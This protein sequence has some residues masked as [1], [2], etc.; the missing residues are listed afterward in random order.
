MWFRIA[1]SGLDFQPRE[2]TAARESRDLEHVS[3]LN[4][5]SS[6]VG[7]TIAWS[8]GCGSSL[9]GGQLLQ[10][11][12]A[13]HINELAVRD[14]ANPY[15]RASLQNSRRGS[16]CVLECATRLEDE[17]AGNKAAEPKVD[18]AQVQPTERRTDTIEASSVSIRSAFWPG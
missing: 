16:S 9:E 13:L 2:A 1:E 17:K 14:S 7:R 11:V 12:V 18:E 8:P 6:G 3:G 4:I 15:T 10:I 5:R